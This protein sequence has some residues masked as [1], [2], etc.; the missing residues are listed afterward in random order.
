MAAAKD[1]NIDKVPKGVSDPR[2]LYTNAEFPK[3]LHK[4]DV[5]HDGAVVGE[6]VGGPTR[7][8]VVANS[9]A[10][11]DAWLAEGWELAPPPKPRQPAKPAEPTPTAKR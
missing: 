3:H 6:D 9:P 4:F 5:G 8:F 10:D 7:R 2:A 1:F 11:V